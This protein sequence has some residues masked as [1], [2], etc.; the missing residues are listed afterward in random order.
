LHKDFYENR[1]I[2]LPPSSTRRTFIA[3]VAIH[4]W[5]DDTLKV[6]LAN[7]R[8]SR[9]ESAEL[10]RILQEAY[11]LYVGQVVTSPSVLAMKATPAV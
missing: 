5:R 10:D 11:N 4:H 3:W 8:G 7:S 2:W 1:P 6:L 9:L